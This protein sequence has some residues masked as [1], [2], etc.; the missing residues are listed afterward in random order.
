MIFH[1]NWDVRSASTLF[2][3]FIRTCSLKNT[4]RYYL[5]S[6]SVSSVCSATMTHLRRVRQ[7]SPSRRNWIIIP[8]RRKTLGWFMMLNLQ[9][10]LSWRSQM[11]MRSR[12]PMDPLRNPRIL[13]PIWSPISPHH[14]PSITLRNL[15]LYPTMWFPSIA[16]LIRRS[17]IRNGQ[18]TQ[19]VSKSIVFV[20]WYK[21]QL[22]KRLI[23]IIIK[24]KNLL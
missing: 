13:F 15:L 12:L 22:F 24:F 21:I 23:N 17:A 5:F 7:Q 14:P 6:L 1:N 4:C 20:Y 18:Y 19:A 2:T 9:K 11:T 8:D 10:I 3:A 16:Q